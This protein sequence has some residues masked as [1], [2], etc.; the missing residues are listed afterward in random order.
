METLGGRTGLYLIRPP[1]RIHKHSVCEEFG[2]QVADERISG[3]FQVSLETNG[4]L[5]FYTHIAQNLGQV[6]VPV[7][8]TPIPTSIRYEQLKQ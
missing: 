7:L 3:R 5:C 4:L 8:Q 2:I 1:W 6:S